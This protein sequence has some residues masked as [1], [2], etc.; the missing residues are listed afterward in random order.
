MEKAAK[1]FAVQVS[2]TTMLINKTT[3]GNQMNL[4]NN[5]SNGLICCLLLIYIQKDKPV[6]TCLFGYVY[7]L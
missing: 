1:R 3:A 4:K 7:I 2:D 5:K 6:T